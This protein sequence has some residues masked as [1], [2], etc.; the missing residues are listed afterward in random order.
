[1]YQPEFEYTHRLVGKLCEIE[2]A[3]RSIN[4]LKVNES[5]A[6]EAYGNAHR[7]SITD[8]LKMENIRVSFDQVRDILAGA[9][10]SIEGG[11]KQVVVNY[12][13]ALHF[14]EKLVDYGGGQLNVGDIK[15]LNKHCLQKIPEAEWHCGNFREIQNWVVDSAKEEI[16]FTPPSPENVMNMLND[17]ILWLKSDES[18]QIHPVI[19]AGIAHHRLMFINPFVY[20]NERAACLYVRYILLHAGCFARNWIWLSGYYVK[21]MSLYYHKLASGLNK[22]HNK[23]GNLTEWLEYFADGVGENF[24]GIEE[25]S[26]KAAVEPAEEAPAPIKEEFAESPVN[27]IDS[28]LIDRL[29]ERQRQ[30]LELG[31]RFS[32]FHRRDILSE[33]DLAGRCHPKTI[34]RDLKAL[35]IMGLLVQRGER[36]GVRYSLADK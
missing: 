7:H 22:S 34:S 2:S 21:D 17:M 10:S 20:G 9:D 4:E 27:I 15:E 8:A 24:L 16:V 32:T 26:K 1:M 29:N 3:A 28:E 12:S 13:E 19:R 31:R 30:I 14:I 18:Q 33:L 23:E 11:V 5:W 6:E 35:V 25:E 36:K